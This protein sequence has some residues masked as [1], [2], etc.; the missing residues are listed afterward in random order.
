[1][2]GSML[3][4]LTRRYYLKVIHSIEGETSKGLKFI[5]VSLKALSWAHNVSITYINH[6]AFNMSS[7]WLVD[8]LQLIALYSYR[9]VANR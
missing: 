6:I 2:I 7:T 9:P 1:M 3:V 8:F 4:L 5:Q